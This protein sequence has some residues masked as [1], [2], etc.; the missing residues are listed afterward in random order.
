LRRLQAHKQVNCLSAQLQKVFLLF[1][2]VLWLGGIS[3]CAAQLKPETAAAFERY[4]RV[5]EAR[6][7]DEARDNRF[8]TIDRLPDLQRQEIYGQLQ[9][10]QIYIEELRTQEDHRPIRVPSGL[11]HHWVGVIF[12]PKATLA[13]TLAVLNDYENEPEI[14]KPAIRRAKLIEQNGNQSKVYQQLFNKSIITVVL[15]GYFDVIETPIGPTRSESA[16]RSTRI[17]EVVNPGDPDEH[18]RPEGN[19]HGYMW[20][21]NSYWRLEEK[22]GGVYVQ[23]QSITLTRGIP[24]L[25]AWLINPLTKSIPRDVLSHMLTDTQKAVLKTRTASR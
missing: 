18:E 23:N 14:Y 19:D 16:S 3:T 4:V 10:G 5:T 7:E 8:L 1:S 12:I 24:V 6:M 17:A 25:L 11:I 21:L 9:R 2:I 22:D 13:E 20:R 15:N